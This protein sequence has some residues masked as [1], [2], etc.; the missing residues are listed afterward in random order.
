MSQE[1]VQVAGENVET[2]QRA[3]EA[4]NLEDLDA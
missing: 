4:W 1:N 2:V 3:Q